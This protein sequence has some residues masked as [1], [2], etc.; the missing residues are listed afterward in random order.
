MKLARRPGAPPGAVE[1][2]NYLCALR[3]P[4]A[5]GKGELP[6][7]WANLFGSCSKQ[8]CDSCRVQT[9]LPAAQRSAPPRDLVAKVKA[10][11]AAH[12]RALILM[13]PGTAV[14]DRRRPPFS[15]VRT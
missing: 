8:G 12:L 5:S 14:D 4:D 9:A 2:F 3:T 6:C 10:A 13:G 1:A 11:C 15:P 7:A